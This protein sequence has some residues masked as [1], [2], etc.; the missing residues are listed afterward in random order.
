MKAICICEAMGV[1]ASLN[2]SANP[3]VFNT[4]LRNSVTKGEVQ[5]AV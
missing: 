1:S 2:R 4:I 3:N 5:L